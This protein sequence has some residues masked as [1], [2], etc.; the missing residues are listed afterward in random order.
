MPHP[1]VYKF[2]KQRNVILAQQEASNKRPKYILGVYSNRVATGKGVTKNTSDRSLHLVDI[3][4]EA[5]RGERLA[6][7]TPRALVRADEKDA[8]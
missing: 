2:P 8:E 1:R 7:C 3:A 4:L 6:G 5:H